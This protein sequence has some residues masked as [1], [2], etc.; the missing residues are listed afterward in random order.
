M[1]K[2]INKTVSNLFLVIPELYY[3]VDYALKDF[4]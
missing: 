4:W 3:V 1:H 2:K